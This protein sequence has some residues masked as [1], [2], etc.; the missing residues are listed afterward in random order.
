MLDARVPARAH[1]AARPSAP[2]F[3]LPPHDHAKEVRHG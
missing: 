3:L 1:D 2:G